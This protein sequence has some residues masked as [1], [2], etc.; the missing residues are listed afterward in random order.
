M[1]RKVINIDEDKCTGCKL[2]IPNCPEGA[3]Q[4]IDG[5]ARLVSDLLCDGLGACIGYCPEGAIHIEEREAEEYDEYKTMDNIVKAGPN[6]IKAHLK[7]LRDHAQEEYLEQALAYLKQKNIVISEEQSDIQGGCSGGG[8][9]GTKAVDLRADK[10]SGQA[11]PGAAD[12]KLNSELTQWPIQL[13]L[14]NSAASYFNDRD[15]VVAADCVPFS[16][17]NFHQKFLKGKALIMFCPKL[18]QAQDDYIEKLTAILKNN[19]VKSIT[20]VRME[21][22]CCYGTVQ[23]V[24]QAVKNSGKTVII[25]EYTISLQG[26]II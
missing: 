8:C 6:T 4:I 20:I 17:A 7:H 12:L 16:Y 14:I 11:N 19:N 9:P 10:N 24:E 5:K 21:V 26:E 25:K 3:L 13:K 2:C 15:L 1:K 22:P 23:A 18:D